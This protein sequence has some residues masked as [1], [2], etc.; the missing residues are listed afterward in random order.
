M[1]RN[2][3]KLAEIIVKINYIHLFIS[4]V[5]LLPTLTATATATAAANMG[6]KR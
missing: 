2:I 4:R 3:I 6:K 1:I 5:L